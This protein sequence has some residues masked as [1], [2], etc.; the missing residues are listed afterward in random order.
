MITS[1]QFTV[2]E[3]SHVFYDASGNRMSPTSPMDPALLTSAWF[4]VEIGLTWSG[5]G[6]Q[7]TNMQKNLLLFTGPPSTS[8]KLLVASQV[9][10][11]KEPSSFLRGQSNFRTVLRT[12]LPVL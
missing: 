10:K 9:I 7:G 4:K 2:K 3:T 12:R 5:T 6:E 1:S 11:Q 8:E